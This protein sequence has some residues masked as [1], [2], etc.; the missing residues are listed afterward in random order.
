MSIEFKAEL[1]HGADLLPQDRVGMV[2]KKKIQSA[3]RYCYICL[4]LAARSCRRLINLG[5]CRCCS[6]HCCS[7]V[8]CWC[9]HQSHTDQ[10]GLLLPVATGE[11]KKSALCCYAWSKFVNSTVRTSILQVLS[12]VYC[13]YDLIFS[14]FS[15]SFKT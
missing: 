14:L 4:F 9:R 5:Y 8:Q 10:G 13:I 15:Y 6:K 2:L 11:K 1:D 12:I 3:A 7:V